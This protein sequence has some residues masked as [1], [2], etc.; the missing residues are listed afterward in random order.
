MLTALTEKRPNRIVIKFIDPIKVPLVILLKVSSNVDIMRPYLS[1]VL[2]NFIWGEDVFKA[3][4]KVQKVQFIIHY[5]SN[6]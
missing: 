5:A 4:K 2:N 3:I 1:R 6:N